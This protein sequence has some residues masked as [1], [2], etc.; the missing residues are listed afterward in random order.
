MSRARGCAR[1]G[2][3][4]ARPPDGALISAERLHLVT[5]VER[6]RSGLAQVLPQRTLPRLS[7]PVPA[8][9]IELPG[10]RAA[11]VP[12]EFPLGVVGVRPIPE[13]N[14]P[15]VDRALLDRL[16]AVRG[17]VARAEY[18]LLQTE[19]HQQMRQVGSVHRDPLPEG[20]GPQR[21][22]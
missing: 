13:R 3:R 17:Q 10:D 8:L 7:A 19:R 16:A 2:L 21:P 22:R 11:W 5:G 1:R 6:V 9:A 12:E 4:G 14:E 20:A 15:G 18:Q